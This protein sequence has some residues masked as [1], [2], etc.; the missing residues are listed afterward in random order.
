MMI[1]MQRDRFSVCA[2]DGQLL[3][4]VHEDLQ[5]DIVRNHGRPAAVL[6]PSGEEEGRRNK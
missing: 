6:R 3:Q 2:G 1:T 5:A 4:M